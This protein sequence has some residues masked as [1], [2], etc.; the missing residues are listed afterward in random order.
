MKTP[1]PLKFT[2][3]GAHVIVPTEEYMKMMTYNLI[4]SELVASG[5]D[6]LPMFDEAVDKTKEMMR[7]LMVAATKK[8]DLN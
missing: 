7:D 3:D 8:G 1:S 2:A 4:L 6:K 5:V